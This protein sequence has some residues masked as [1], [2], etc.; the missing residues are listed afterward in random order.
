MALVQVMAWYYL[1]ESL[2]EPMLAQ[3]CYALGRS[4]LK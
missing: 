3:I 1:K 4:E 2:L